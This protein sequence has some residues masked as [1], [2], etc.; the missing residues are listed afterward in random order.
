MIF[1]TDVILQLARRKEFKEIAF[2]GIKPVI[3]Y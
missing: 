1:K 3:L 2:N